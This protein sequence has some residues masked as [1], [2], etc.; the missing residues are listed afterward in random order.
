MAFRMFEVTLRLRVSQSVC[1]GAEHPCGTCDQILLP[2][3]MLL[4]E[5]CGH[6]SVARPLWREGGSV[7]CS[8]FTQWSDSQRT[9]NHALLSHLYSVCY[10]MAS[11]TKTFVRVT[12]D[13]Q[14]IPRSRCST[15]VCTSLSI[16]VFVT[17]AP[18]KHLEY[19]CK[20]LFETPCT[21]TGR[22]TSPI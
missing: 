6:A 20:A 4:S 1:L 16:N 13:V 12:K 8:V 22:N 21:L 10:S 14:T 11:V 7:I 9:R 5:T 3:G 17:L 19:Q 2:V 15:T 18:Q